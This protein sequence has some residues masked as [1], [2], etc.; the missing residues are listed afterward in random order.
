MNA[1]KNIQFNNVQQIGYIDVDKC[2]FYLLKIINTI[3]DSTRELVI[4]IYGAEDYANHMANTN[5][6][7]LYL[8]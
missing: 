3:V 1:F 7:F 2:F 6:I 5:L 4:T 8:I